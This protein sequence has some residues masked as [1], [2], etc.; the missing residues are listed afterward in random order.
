M[1]TPI[2]AFNFTANDLTV[3]FI[4][5]TIGDVNTYLWE[6]GFSV[7][8]VPQTSN[9]K[10]P[11]GIVF[12]SQAVY[13]IKLTA[14]NGDGVAVYEFPIS[15]W[16]GPG[17][18]LTI[19]ELVAGEFPGGMSVSPMY[20]SQLVRKWQLYLQDSQGISNADV[21][22]ESKWT[23]L[24]NVLIAKLVVYDL[25]LIAQ[26]NVITSMSSSGHSSILPASP[27]QL[28]TDFS[29]HLEYPVALN[30]IS[31]LVNGA[32]IAGP[33]SAIH[34]DSE[35]IDWLNTLNLGSFQL[36]GNAITT[37]GNSNIFTKIIYSTISNAQQ[38]EVLFTAAN[39]RLS[40]QTT[41]TST[42]NFTGIQGPVK[43]ITT[44]PSDVEWVDL[45]TY[46][47]NLLKNGILLN[48]ES[49]LC[50]LGYK[51]GIRLWFCPPR[52]NTKVFI[53]GRKPPVNC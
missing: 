51:L 20:Y 31:L 35:M 14:T 41:N 9:L 26:R 19:S 38:L 13:N 27:I 25:I 40:A 16:A 15:L 49:E 17:I 37:I 43:K 24:G 11:T 39:Q 22:N 6:F 47:A 10:N 53:V 44:G 5:T 46:W 28:L 29:I 33:V 21:F 48:V 4:D 52:K 36:V 7:M 3:N 18:N 8:G 23:P 1:A 42:S 45:S 34:N 32:T 2:P 50:M 12:P 30:I